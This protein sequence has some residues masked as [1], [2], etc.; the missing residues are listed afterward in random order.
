[1]RVADLFSGCGGLSSGFRAAGHDI[2][3]AADTWSRAR[4]AYD[5]NFDQASDRLDLSDVIEAAHAVSRKSPE[6]IVGGP[7]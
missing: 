5:A 1:V 3:F 7:P 4:L 6:I 2:V